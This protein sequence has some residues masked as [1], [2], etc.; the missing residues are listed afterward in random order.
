MTNCCG[1][2]CGNKTAYLE[3]FVNT[4]QAIKGAHPT[5]RVGGPAT[6][7]LAWLDTFLEG[8]VAAKCDPD[9]LSTHL[10][11]TDP[12]INHTRDGFAEAIEDAVGVASSTAAK[13][14]KETPPILITEFNCGLGINCADA[15]YAAS[16]VAHQ[17]L[18]AQRTAGSVVME[19]YWTFSDVFE[20]QG[21]Q[22]SEFSQAF[23]AQSINGVP[24]PV[25]RAMQ[26]LRRL[27][28]DGVAVS[29][30]PRGNLAAHNETVDVV[31]TQARLPDNTS[32]VVEAMVSNHPGGPAKQ[33]EWFDGSL[34]AFNAAHLA[35]HI[36]PRDDQS[37]V[38]VTIAFTG[39]KPPVVS[40]RR[41]DDQHSN[42]LRAYANMG[43]P[44]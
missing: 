38:N 33:P 29:R 22:P 41:V 35:G 7:Q 28:P 16:M 5:L 26:L 9:F 3:L 19:S 18:R 2:T 17:A 37:A 27:L 12:Y 23:G 39:P 25:Y 32:F 1:P 15:P 20:E 8:A 24:K 36:R 6:A 42:A 44:P 13:L 21:Q 10:Y 31:V 11:P 34:A 14:G 43:R 4:F 30:E 40:V